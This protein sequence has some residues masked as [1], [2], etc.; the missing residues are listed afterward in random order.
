MADKIGV[1]VADAVVGEL[2]KEDDLFIYR[3]N[4]QDPSCYISLTMQVRERDFIHP[5]LHP[6][7]EM[8]LPEGYLLSVIKK[9]FSKIVKIDD[10][11]LLQ[12]M[13]PSIRGR[14]TYQSAHNDHDDQLNLDSLLHTD[15]TNLFDE[16]VRRFALRSPLSGVQPKVLATIRD[17][18]TLSLEQYIIKSWGEEYPHLG[19]NEYY[20]MRVVQQAGIRVPEFYLSDDHRLFIMKRFDVLEDGSALGFEDMC[21]LQAK[22][23]E[24]KY[25][26]SYESIA[27]TIKMFV[28]AHHK[29]RALQDFFKMV[30]INNLLQ[31]G[32]AH[33]K[34]FGLIYRDIDDIQL[35]PAYDVVCTTLYIQND[36]PALHLLG[37]KKWWA[38]KFLLR[39][40]VESCDLSPS[41]AAHLYEVCVEAVKKVIKEIDDQ[42]HKEN[43]QGATEMLGRLKFVLENSK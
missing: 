29:T 10:F 1:Q 42:L 21:V 28:S 35:A 36:I 38:K 20:C 4:T 33:L 22:Q 26:G 12:L 9:H 8:H 24:D 27:K 7:F 41:K 37:S 16:L 15:D 34:N 31:N 17:K 18:A 2:I 11:S 43:D 40:G 6:I 3:Y 23:R 5:A 25:E 13:A 30:V 32:D 39:F 19:L 14:V